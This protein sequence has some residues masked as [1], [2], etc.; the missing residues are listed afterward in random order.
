MTL[1]MTMPWKF[2]VGL[3]LTLFFAILAVAP[4]LTP[5]RHQLAAKINEQTLKRAAAIKS[6]SNEPFP[7]DRAVRRHERE[8]RPD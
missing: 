2:A 5:A 4:F 8:Q 1:M 7:Y 6:A 3:S